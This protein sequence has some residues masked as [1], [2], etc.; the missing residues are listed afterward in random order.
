[1]CDGSKRIALRRTGIV[2]AD[3]L[4]TTDDLLIRSTITDS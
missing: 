2:D 3:R 4:A 1:M